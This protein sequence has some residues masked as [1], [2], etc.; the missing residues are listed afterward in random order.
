MFINFIHIFYS[1][2]EILVSIENYYITIY[3]FWRLNSDKMYPKTEHILSFIK[4][5]S[6]NNRSTFYSDVN[7]TN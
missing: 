2:W 6:Q 5:C 3:F 1:K 4:K 7:F